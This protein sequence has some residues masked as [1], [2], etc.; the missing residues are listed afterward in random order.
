MN[1][2]VNHVQNLAPLPGGARAEYAGQGENGFQRVIITEI[3]R[4]SPEPEP[5]A[6]GNK[7]AGRGGDLFIT[8]SA[9]DWIA[10]AA[11]RPMSNMLFDSFWFENELCILFAESGAGKSALAT[12]I[13][14]A[15]AS[16][17]SIFN[18]QIKIESAEQ[19]VLYFDFE[20]SDKQIEIRYSAKSADS[21]TC[22]DHYE[23]SPNFLRAEMS[24]DFNKPADQPF[25]DYLIECL[26]QAIIQEGV[27][28]VVID[29]ITFLRTETERAKDALPLMKKLKKLKSA[30]NL[31]ILVL[32]HTPKRDLSKPLTRNDLAGSKMLIN[33]A[34]SAFTLGESAKDSG[35]RYLKQIKVRNCAMSYD[36]DNVVVCSLGKNKE[37]FLGFEFIAYG[38]ESEHL[39]EL[40]ED[41]REELIAKI[42]QLN[43]SGKTQRSIAEQVGVSQAKVS[44][45]INE[46]NKSK[47]K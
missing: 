35:V 22:V 15:I 19:K 36:A 42:L 10:E 28:V 14:N 1:G 4:L 18:G 9:N 45:I 44:R 3:N 31:S 32:A 39:R 7:H 26:E 17:S 13:A 2:K 12:Q 30:L 21:K 6:N 24:S 41:K 43:G 34:D 25:E 16:A 11:T 33:F 5:T 40:T 46:S 37:N 38:H 20:L 8:K 27:R 29:N 23:F 47:S